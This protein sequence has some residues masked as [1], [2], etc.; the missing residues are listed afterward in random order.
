MKL[1][2]ALPLA[3]LVA[4]GR[5]ETATPPPVPAATAEPASTQT[6][7][8]PLAPASS[9]AALDPVAGPKLTPSDEGASDAAFVAYRDR[10]RDAVKNRDAKAVVALA[11]PKIRTSF[12]EGGG[13][14]A[15]EQL[16]ARPGMWERLGTVL[17]HGGS[18]LGEERSAFWAPYVYSAWPDRQ[19]AFTA[20]AIIAENVPLR[21][22]AGATTGIL[23]TLSYDIV[24][25]ISPPDESPWVEVKT[26]DGR[27]GFVEAKYVLSPVGYRAGF[28]KLNGEW[29]MTALVA[30]D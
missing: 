8:T 10:L 20:I 4:C 19:D 25:R 2:I 26:A 27:K 13:A 16:L 17:A 24:E 5:Q 23:A 6:S 18:F 7:T 11:D 1:L 29:R 15:L 22:G 12:G 3:V 14:N 30:G 9:P 28:N 21:Q